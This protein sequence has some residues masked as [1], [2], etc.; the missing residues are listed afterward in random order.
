MLEEYSNCLLIE[1]ETALNMANGSFL[2]ACA[3][4][5]KTYEGT[6]L[7]GDRPAVYAA[8]GTET[9]ALADALANIPDGSPQEIADYMAGT[10]KVQ[11]GALREAVDTAEG[12]CEDALWPVPTYTE[13]L[14][15]HHGEY[16]EG[17]FM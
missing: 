11:M 12:L 6:G 9:K 10:V 8:I 4:D 5:L 3:Q 2:P 7:A 16:A 17:D 15:S 1:A 14:F 13:M